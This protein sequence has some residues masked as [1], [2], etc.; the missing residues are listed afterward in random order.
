MKKYLRWI[1]GFSA[2]IFVLGCAPVTNSVV[3]QPTTNQNA[4]QITANI[5][6]KTI[7]VSEIATFDIPYTATHEQINTQKSIEIATKT[8]G[9]D[10][11][12]EIEATVVKPSDIHVVTIIQKGN[13]QFGLSFKKVTIKTPVEIM[14]KVKQSTTSKTIRFNL[15]P[16][17]TITNISHNPTELVLGKSFDYNLTPKFTTQPNNFFDIPAIRFMLNESRKITYDSSNPN[18]ATVSS[19]GV[20]R[21]IKDGVTNISIIHDD[22]TA[23]VKITVVNLIAPQSLNVSQPVVNLKP[24]SSAIVTLS[25]NPPGADLELEPWEISNQT[26]GKIEKQNNQQYEITALSIGTTTFTTSSKYYPHAKVSISLTVSTNLVNSLSL[27]T[28]QLELEKGQ[29]GQLKAIILPA[30]APQGIIWS[31]DAE[32]VVKVDNSGLITAVD[33]GTAVITATSMAN[34]NKRDI[35]VVTVAPPVQSVSLSTNLVELAYG[36]SYTFTPTVLPAQSNQ[37]VVYTVDDSSFF[38]FTSTGNFMAKNKAGKAVV[39][40]TSKADSTKKAKAVVYIAQSKVSS[41]ITDKS[42]I[43]MDINASVE[44][45]ITVNPISSTPDIDYTI[46]GNNLEI[47]NEDKNYNRV[48]YTLKAGNLAET[49]KIIFTSKANPTKKVEVSVTTQVPQVTGINL[50]NKTIVL[51]QRNETMHATVLPANALQTVQWESSKTEVVRIDSNSGVLTPI[52]LG[53]STITARSTQNPTITATAT[54]TV[55]TLITDFKL[56]KNSITVW[57]DNSA[58]ITATPTPSDAFSEYIWQCDNDDIDIIPNT[59]D[60]KTATIRVNKKNARSANAT[61]TVKSK[62]NPNLAAQTSQLTLK[63]IVPTSIEIVGETKMYKDETLNFTVTANPRYQSP[64]RDNSVTWKLQGSYFNSHD[65][66]FQIS[67]DGKL[68]VKDESYKSMLRNKE[69]ITLVATSTLDSSIKATKEITIYDNVATIKTVSIDENETTLDLYNS[70]R[71]ITINF[72]GTNNQQQNIYKKILITES[73]NPWTTSSSNYFEEAVYTIYSS[74]ITIQPKTHTSARTI[75]FYIFPIDPKTE[76]PVTTDKTKTVNLVIWSKP[77]SIVLEKGN[78]NLTSPSNN[79]YNHVSNYL[80]HNS[81]GYKVKAY[82][83]PRDSAKQNITV[84]RD[85]YSGHNH[86]VRDFDY[87]PNTQTC[88]FS[89]TQSGLGVHERSYLVFT[90]NSPASYTSLITKLLIMS[91]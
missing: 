41:L 9:S 14:F 38:N 91:N 26:V 69:T 71:N 82:V 5:L 20:V 58:T 21:T 57:Y 64:E 79:I 40:V 77:T 33:F 89:T 39:T 80:T 59:N 53:E 22:K 74:Y 2:I 62:T 16:E 6:G 34:A 68:S 44:V 29:Q 78:F 87:D 7:N 63:T 1:I 43:T 28:T 60:P 67:E 84:R 45:S 11:G 66:Y 30:L 8:R 47:V 12:K 70:D 24:G 55:K 4:L 88:T 76:R 32:N 15:L 35:C 65:W 13:G 48:T 19:Q 86:A 27:K 37:N 81:S 75:T 51:G 56:N 50:A 23:I 73:S 25:S 42:S 85:S 83:E 31:S 18:V 61:I 54:V 36:E 52:G 10:I 17:P 46:E 49:K 90:N 72:Q 3:N